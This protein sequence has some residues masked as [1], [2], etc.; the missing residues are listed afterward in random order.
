[1]L[2]QLMEIIKSNPMMTTLYSGG[3]IAVIVANFRAIVEFIVPLH[4]EVL[5][6]L[7]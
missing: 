1:M 2:E 6:L 7:Q 5:V 3:I 4:F